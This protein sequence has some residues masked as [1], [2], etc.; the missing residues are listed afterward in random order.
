MATEQIVGKFELICVY[1]LLASEH[2]SCLVGWPAFCLAER[3]AVARAPDRRADRQLNLIIIEFNVR[4]RIKIANSF[5]RVQL[6]ASDLYGE[7]V[8]RVVTAITS[9]NVETHGFRQTVDPVH[10]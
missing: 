3:R 9:C 2:F 1:F 10:L 5:F 8:D 6:S 4:K 7:R